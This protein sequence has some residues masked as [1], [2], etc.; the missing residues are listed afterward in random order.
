M[1]RRSN[2]PPQS[3]DAQSVDKVRIDKW[4][5]AARFFK[6]RG[7]AIDAIKGGKVSH[8]GNRVKPSKEVQVGDELSVRQGY[9]VKTVIVKAL[10]DK[11]GPA[12]QAALLYEETPHSRQKREELKAQLMS[13][14]AMRRHGLGRPTKR[15]RRKIVAFTAK[16]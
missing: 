4:L 3:T 8:A 10:S 15:E 13:Q 14:P 2:S 1:S 9:D 7:L 12:P 11:R 16:S 6:T 5:W